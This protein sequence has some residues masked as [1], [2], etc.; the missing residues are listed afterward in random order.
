MS[1]SFG[2]LPKFPGEEA[3]QRE[4]LLEEMRTSPEP[5]DALGD[6]LRHAFPAIVMLVGL[7]IGLFVATG[8]VILIALRGLERGWLVPVLMVAV[9]LAL[10]SVAIGAAFYQRAKRR[11]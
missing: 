4:R 6:R 8:L 3:A 11:M 9:F 2:D 5:Q 1:G 7:A 10:P